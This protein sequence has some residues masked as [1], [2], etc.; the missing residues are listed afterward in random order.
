MIS[1]SGSLVLL[2]GATV[3]LVSC[4]GAGDV[5]PSETAAGA[6][7]PA[8]VDKS[9]LVKK[10]LDS[11]YR[12]QLDNKRVIHDAIELEIQKCMKK[13]GFN[14]TLAEFKIEE[15]PP[16]RIGDVEYAK[17][18]GFGI[19]SDFNKKKN[20]PPKN[21]DTAGMS[22]AELAAY[23]EAFG[24]KIIGLNPDTRDTDIVSVSTEEGITRAR[25][26]SCV[27]QAEISVSGDLEQWM[28]L[29]ILV[30]ELSNKIRHETAKD[31]RMIAANKNWV[32]C[33]EKA[34]FRSLSELDHID[35][36]SEKITNNP[37]NLDQIKKEEIAVATA[38]AQCQ[39][40]INFAA[41]FRA[42]QADAEKKLLAENQG[43]I[44]RWAEMNKTA[45]EKAKKILNK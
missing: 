36:I 17:R 1:R 23:S 13:K 8:V 9:T 37:N 34:G 10:P 4:S 20:S 16:D 35:V 6:S 2:L 26:S 33:M 41:T 19:V 3:G 30:N 7:S 27:S 24:G 38:S 40:D 15:D 22:E 45:A 11:L 32:S 5:P 44:T 42:A 28:L 14:Y 25:K 39:K 29:P 31:P 21:P 43:L 18:E 12:S